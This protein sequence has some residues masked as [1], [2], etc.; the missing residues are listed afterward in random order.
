MTKFDTEIVGK[1]GSMALI[2][3]TYQ[4]MD[5]NI[6]AKLSRELRPG[7]IWVTSGATEIGKL[8]YIKRNGC[9]LTGNIDDIKADYS[10]QGQSILMAK[11]REFMDSKYSLR[12]ILVEHQHFNDE[13]KR[14]N[15]KR[16]LMRAKEQNAIPIINYNDALCD[17]ENRRLEI[18]NLAR[19]KA[20]A[21]LSVDNDETASLIADLVKAETLLLLSVVDGI[22][23]NPKDEKTL[24]KHI[25]GKD[26]YELLDN[27]ECC[28]KLCVGASRSGSNGAR[29]KLEYI[30]KPLT[31]G[32][33]V[34]ISNSKYSIKSILSGEAPRTLI[35]L[36]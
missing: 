33:R 7:M 21:F 2:N 28:Q 11:Y 15:L 23:E 31:N 5:Y 20:I 35:S 27:V 30:K 24:I 18:S 26:I 13:L 6:I 19:Q 12:Q 34:I 10:A 25:S 17:E 1:V 29:A 22:Y 32:T 3:T 36:D 9:A 14:E 8:D 16:I 4:D